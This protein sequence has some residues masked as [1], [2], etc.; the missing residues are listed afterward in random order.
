MKLLQT[1]L[2]LFLL[3]VIFA[4][5]T[6]PFQKATHSA[7]F[8]DKTELMRTFFHGLSSNNYIITAPRHFGKTTNMIMMKRFFEICRTRKQTELNAKVFF[9]KSLHLSIMRH[10]KFVNEHYGRHPVIYVN[11]LIQPN[12]N[13]EDEIVDALRKCICRAFGPYKFLYNGTARINTTV[14]KFMGTAGSVNIREYHRLCEPTSDEKPPLGAIKKALSMLGNDLAE[15]YSSSSILLVDDFDSPIMIATQNGLNIT[16]ITTLI[17]SILSDALDQ[18]PDQIQ[19][20]LLTGTLDVLHHSRG[21]GLTNFF[22]YQ[23]LLDGPLSEY[24][25]FTIS[26]MQNLYNSSKFNPPVSQ[27]E[28]DY[29][30]RCY[31]GYVTQS[32]QTRLY[33][34][35]SVIGYFKNRGFSDSLTPRADCPNHWPKSNDLAKFDFCIKE[36]T[37]RQAL[38]DLIRNTTAELRLTMRFDMEIEYFHELYQQNCSLKDANQTE[39][40]WTLLFEIGYFTYTETPG[41]VKFPNLEVKTYLATKLR[42]TF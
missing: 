16:G 22:H 34:P 37:I 32:G 7:A 24:F 35:V 21:M 42:I 31:N 11:F 2:L 29:I 18:Y 27:V 30:E 39:F 20:S 5:Y 14:L 19:H 4:I 1:L 9:N 10:Q 6:C 3:P 15:Y 12:K 13:T 26:E 8:I 17:S 40:Y 41:Y 25:G 36:G 33:N 23:F 38:S 28:R